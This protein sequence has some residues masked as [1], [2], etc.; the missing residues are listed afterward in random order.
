MWLGV[1][2]AVLLGGCSEAFDPRLPNDDTFAVY[3]TLDGREAVQRLRVQD[4]ALPVE[5][6]PEVLPAT[7]TSTEAGS[8]RTTVWRDS[9]VRLADGSRDHL[10]TA[11]LAL[12]PGEIHQIRAERLADG[13]ATTVE[14]RLPD[15]SVALGP[16][17]PEIAIRVD[18][19]GLPAPPAGVTIRYR[20]RL[21]ATER[22][23]RASYGIGVAVDGPALL[24]ELGRDA[25]R[26]QSELGGGDGEVE[27][28]SITLETEVEP[29]AP[30]PVAG[31]LGEVGWILP[32][33][34]PLDLLPADI[35]AAGLVD[36]RGS[37]GRE[38]RPESLSSLHSSLS[39]H[40]VGREPDRDAAKGPGGQ[41]A[42]RQAKL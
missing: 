5:G 13:A 7:V 9:L 18:L 40:S 19:V 35:E 6:V 36:A 15:P 12:R 4:L 25:Q 23:V 42:L 26:L 20:A 29:E 39:L 16:A 8:N 22:E 37:A 11:P 34:L 28:L 10:F 38:R 21:G 2:C 30:S 24:L 3:G 17:S 27:L 41:P 1:A 32:I 33:T 31:G 14:I